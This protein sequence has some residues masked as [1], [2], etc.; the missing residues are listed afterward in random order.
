MY[1]TAQ[2]V[3]KK[4][5]ATTTT[6]T[7]VETGIRPSEK[8]HEMLITDV[9]ARGCWYVDAGQSDSSGV[10]SYYTLYPPYHD[11]TMGFNKSGHKVTEGFILVSGPIVNEGIRTW[12]PPRDD[13]FSYPLIEQEEGR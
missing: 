4:Y 2:E 13:A 12:V 10:R 9:E 8:L 7:I 5:G 1:D 11:W 3:I 6:S